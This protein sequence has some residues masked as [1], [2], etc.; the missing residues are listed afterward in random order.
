M[1]D[2]TDQQMYCSRIETRISQSIW[3][4]GIWIEETNGDQQVYCRRIET[5]ISQSIHFG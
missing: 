3:K 4:M 2:W 5:W 1:M